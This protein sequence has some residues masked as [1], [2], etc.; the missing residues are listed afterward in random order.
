MSLFRQFISRLIS[1]AT[2]GEPSG[3]PDYPAL[4]T[5]DTLYCVGDV[6]GRLD[7]LERVHAAI[8]RDRASRRADRSVEVYL[9]DYIDRGPHSRQ[10]LDALMERR[11]RVDCVLLRG[12]HEAALLAVAEGA[13]ELDAWRS[14]GGLET[15]LSY[16]LDPRIVLNAGSEARALIVDAIPERHFALLASLPLS[17]AHGPYFFAHAGIRPGV[18]LARQTEADLLWIREPF[19][20]ARGDHG[21]VVVH[22]HTPAPEAEWLHNRINL[23]LGAYATGRLAC[24][25]FDATG[26]SLLTA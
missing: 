6:H 21:A 17:Y 2:S 24:A 15:L 26:V 11:E 7:C 12:N 4:P 13:L 3:P 25:R 9:G 5:G 1:A 22:G 14:V 20:T 10:V 8:D 18:A 16:G 23:D 19:L